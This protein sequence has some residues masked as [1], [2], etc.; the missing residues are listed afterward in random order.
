MASLLIAAAPFVAFSNGVHDNCKGFA[1]VCRSDTPND[2]QA[3]T[4][5]TLA[6]AAGL[7]WVML[8]IV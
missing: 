3:L 1:A 2:R 7:T 4:L 5:D 6:T 8:K